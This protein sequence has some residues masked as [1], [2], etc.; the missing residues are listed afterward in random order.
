[1]YI[2]GS[3]PDTGDLQRRRRI[4]PCPADLYRWQHRELFRRC[5]HYP[6][7][8]TDI[9]DGLAESYARHGNNS[10]GK[11][12]L[13]SD[14]SLNFT[15]GCD[16][17]RFDFAFSGES[18]HRDQRQSANSRCHAQR[19]HSAHPFS[20]SW[21]ARLQCLSWG[22]DANIDHLEYRKC[23]TEV[24]GRPGTRCPKF[25]EARRKPQHCSG[26]RSKC[27]GE[28]D[29]GRNG[30]GWRYD[31]HDYCGGQSYRPAH[32]CCD[33][34]ES[35]H[36]TDHDPRCITCS[37]ARCVT[38]SHACS[39]TRCATCAADQQYPAF[40]RAMSGTASTPQSVIVTNPGADPV[41]WTASVPPDASWLQ[42]S[43][44]SDSEAPGATSTITFSVDA[45]HLQPGV[46]R[47]V[48]TITPAGGTPIQVI[49]SLR[50]A[51]TT[52]TPAAIATTA[53]T[54][55]PV[56]SSTSAIPAASSTATPTASP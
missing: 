38:C 11:R 36:D 22:G 54:A 51:A 21:L 26:R 13:P 29:C 6:N 15:A 42:V 37:F 32:R 48:V 41:T 52:P 27:R 46:Y 34:R 1:M 5:D 49:V 3:F 30:P 39:H 9:W 56:A 19:A 35:H 16:V 14:G 53:A 25:C 17:Y 47:T 23:A 4:K 28:G 7:G 8:D 55:T 33:S 20:R 12:D 10:R 44:A 31:I 24:D 18:R 40:F 45:T 43:P 2:A 50:V